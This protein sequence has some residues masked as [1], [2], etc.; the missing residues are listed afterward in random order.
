MLKVPVLTNLPDLFDDVFFQPPAVEPSS[1]LFFTTPFEQF[2]VLWGATSTDSL[3]NLLHFKSR[4]DSLEGL[5]KKRK[6]QILSQLSQH[7][8]ANLICPGYLKLSWLGFQAQKIRL[9]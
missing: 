4:L 9:Y 5:I 8:R 6:S 2:R 3:Q 7:W 1:Q